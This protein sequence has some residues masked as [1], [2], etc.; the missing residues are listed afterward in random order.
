MHHYI[1]AYSMKSGVLNGDAAFL[2]AIRSWGE[3]QEISTAVW[4]LKTDYSL[5]TVRLFLSLWAKS[6]YNYKVTR[7]DGDLLVALETIMPYFVLSES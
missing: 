7:I 6:R 5:E 2:K 4:L 3:T 1:I